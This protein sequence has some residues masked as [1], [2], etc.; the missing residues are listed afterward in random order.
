MPFSYVEMMNG[1]GLD[2]YAKLPMFEPS[3][4]APITKQLPEA[5]VGL[6]TSVGALMTNHRSFQ[7]V[8]DLTFRLLPR[9]VPVS[10]LTFEHPS[11]I[12][13]YAL[14]DLNVAYPRDRLIELE[15]EGL[16]KTLAPNAISM[17]GSITT[18]TQ[19]LEK[20]V[21][22]LTHVYREM[23][24]DLVLLVPFCPA[25][26]R[27][28][29]MIARGLEASGIPTIMLTVLREM[30]M[31]FKPARPIFLDFPL[32]ATV[33]KPHQHELQR[34]IL[35]E[36]LTAGAAMDGA[37]RIHDLP[38]T[39]TEDG[40]RAWEDEVR[41]IYAVTGRSVHRARVQEHIEQG[42]TLVGREQQIRISCD[43]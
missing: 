43:C 36:A 13:G 33:G 25:C 5:T 7:P 22:G 10:A 31:A 32:G 6:F 1:F 40:S 42:E 26:H 21:P 8:N 27:A 23:D 9:E 39:W 24:V 14:E 20:T 4:R 12:R 38:F 37:W 19:L 16:F 35:R 34:A 41:A 30:A 17:L 28:T 18:Y 29:A 3:R 2:D 15:S 11:P